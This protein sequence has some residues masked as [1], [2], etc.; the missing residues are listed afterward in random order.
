M[1][2]AITKLSL[3]DR[4]QHL[5]LEEAIAKLRVKDFQ[6]LDLVHLI[7]ELEIVAGRDRAEIESR[8]GVLLAHL[9]KRLYV[10]SEYDYRGWEITIREQRRHLKI[11]LQQSPSLKRFFVE[12]FDR[13]WQDALIEVREDYPQVSFP[14]QWQFSRD[15]DI[16]LTQ[17]FWE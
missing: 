14:D 5:W 16:L 3:Y 12:A 8:L 6:S 17:K 11:A 1:T 15:V 4:D 10:Q 2:Q 7:E 13:A 9:L